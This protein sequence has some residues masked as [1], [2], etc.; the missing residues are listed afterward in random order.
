MASEARATT[1]F[2]LTEENNPQLR[3]LSRLPKNIRVV[4]GKTAADAAPIAPEID[5][6]LA[7]SGSIGGAKGDIP[8][9]LE[10]AP[11]LKWIHTRWAGMD[12]M[13]FP[14][15]IES[16]VIVTNAKGVFAESLAEFVLAAILFF[17]KD[18][19]RMRRNQKEGVWEP[20]D[21]EVISGKSV[22]IFGFG[23]IGRACG[24]KCAALGMNVLASRRNPEKAKNEPLV[25]KFYAPEQLKEMAAASDY[26]VVTAPLTPETRG[27]MNAEVFKA[28]PE[29]AVFINIG[30]GAVVDEKALTA[31]LQSKSIRGA[32]LDVFIEEPLPKEHPFYSLENV[33][34]SPHTADHTATWLDDTMNC[35]I[36]NAIRF[37]KGESLKNI[38]D[39][40]L[41]Y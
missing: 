3:L 18:F 37:S 11:N 21:V 25:K 26:F 28:L 19:P 12:S 36:E 35:F 30:R 40:K 5:A 22:G 32:A 7:W 9:M 29:H 38:V 1:I 34:L 4:T 17:A 2:V 23:E 14:G 13:L 15:L 10:L 24:A 6:V 41:G 8:Q 39:K 16:P 20:F 31:A 33:L 27:V